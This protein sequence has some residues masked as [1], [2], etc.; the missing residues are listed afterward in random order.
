MKR[1]IHRF[2]ELLLSEGFRQ[3]RHGTCT[4]RS[5]LDPIVGMS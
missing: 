5:C 2:E 1:G 4:E 3:E